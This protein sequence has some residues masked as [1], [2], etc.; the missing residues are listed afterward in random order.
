MRRTLT[1][2]LGLFYTALALDM[3]LGPASWFAR[4]PGVEATGP[5][6]PHFVRDVGLAFLASGLAFLA[7]AAFRWP[8]LWPAALGGSL[9]PL[10]HAFFHLLA[11][12]R[13]EAAASLLFELALIV[14]PAGLAVVVAW[15][16]KNAFQ[17]PTT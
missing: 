7:F 2:L 12:A 6:N 14:L 17:Q 8:A 15:P 16:P 5:F 9:F 10:F 11:H 3:I 13:G 1:V 4:I